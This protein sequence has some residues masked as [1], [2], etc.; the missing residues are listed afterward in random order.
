MMKETTQKPTD[1]LTHPVH[2]VNC[3]PSTENLFAYTI[4]SLESAGSV[5]S[6]SKKKQTPTQMECVRIAGMLKAFQGPISTLTHI[7]KAQESGAKSVIFTFTPQGKIDMDVVEFD[8]KVIVYVDKHEK[9]GKPV[10][11]VMPMDVDKLSEEA[12][13]NVK[14]GYADFKDDRKSMLKASKR[15]ALTKLHPTLDAAKEDAAITAKIFQG[16][17]VLSALCRRD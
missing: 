9:A 17:V 2:V 10:F 5:P 4:E 7:Q 13:K 3:A 1:E 6:F 11:E 8:E 16:R 14:T 15:F 12:L